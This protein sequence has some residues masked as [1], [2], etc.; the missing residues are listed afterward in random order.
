MQRH[1]SVSAMDPLWLWGVRKRLAWPSPKLLPCVF[2]LFLFIFYVIIFGPQMLRGMEDSSFHDF[3]APL[4]ANHSIRDADRKPDTTQHN[5]K[6]PLPATVPP[7]PGQ[8][9]AAAASPGKA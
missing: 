2:L 1:Q 9:V 5:P 7:R 6:P 8:P 3:A 4:N